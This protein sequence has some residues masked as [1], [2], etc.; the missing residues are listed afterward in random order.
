M[1]HTEALSTKATFQTWCLR[2]FEYQFLHRSSKEN[3]P[4]TWF[5]AGRIEGSGSVNSWTEDQL[6]LLQKGLLFSAFNFS[7]KGGVPCYLSNLA[8]MMSCVCPALVRAEK[9]MLI[10]RNLKGK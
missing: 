7:K 3:P 8:M 10:G 4:L 9:L 2:S 1:R 5:A 6:E